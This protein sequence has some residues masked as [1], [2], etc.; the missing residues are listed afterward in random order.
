MSDDKRTFISL[1]GLWKKKDKNGNTMLV[2]GP[3][4][5]PFS[6]VVIKNTKKDTDNHPDYFLSIS[7]SN[8]E[9]SGKKKDDLDDEE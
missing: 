4:N 2:G 9:K 7:S 5:S 8:A 3:K 1:T 6:F